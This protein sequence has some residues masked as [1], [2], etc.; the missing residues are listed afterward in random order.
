MQRTGGHDPAL[1]VAVQHPLHPDTRH[2]GNTDGTGNLHMIFEAAFGC[3]QII[4][5]EPRM[6]TNEHEFWG[7]HR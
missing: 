3:N 1:P 7:D 5:Y 4:D 6:N 2:V